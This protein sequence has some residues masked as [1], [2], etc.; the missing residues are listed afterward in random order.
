MLLLCLVLLRH[1]LRLCWSSPRD[2]HAQP[3]LPRG[4]RGDG[5]PSPSLPIA[6]HMRRLAQIF[7]HVVIQRGGTLRSHR[8]PPLHVCLQVANPSA[9][10]EMSAVL[11]LIA[12]LQARNGSTNQPS[13]FRFLFRES[14]P[15]QV[16]TLRSPLVPVPVPRSRNVP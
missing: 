9:R 4:R 15:E 3:P 14:F 2:V 11:I 6:V 16:G 12:G 5:R 10:A 1:S 8:S 7:I 13:A